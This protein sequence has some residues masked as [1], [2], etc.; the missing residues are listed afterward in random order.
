MHNLYAMNVAKAK[1]KAADPERAV[2]KAGTN[3]IG[4]S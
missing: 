4:T 1:S 2:S 3:E